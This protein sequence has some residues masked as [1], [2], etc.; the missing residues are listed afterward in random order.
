V[1]WSVW[2][3]SEAVGDFGEDMNDILP[4]THKTQTPKARSVWVIGAIG[5]VILCGL[6]YGVFKA[7]PNLVGGGDMSRF[8]VG[9]MEKLDVLKDP[10]VQPIESFLGPDGAPTTLSAFKG[11]VVLVNLWATWCAPCITE[12]PTLADLQLDFADQDF[13]VV[14]V[15]VDRETDAN[16]AKTKLADLSKGSLTFFHD[17]RMAIVYPMRARGF[18]TSV[19]YDREGKEVARLAGEADWHSPEAHALIEAALARK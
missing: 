2:V 9:Q 18:P 4:E 13:M 12:M 8:K 7:M 16:E 6:L 15:S 10:P 5:G 3:G 1:G 14:A 17:P 19:L 11:K